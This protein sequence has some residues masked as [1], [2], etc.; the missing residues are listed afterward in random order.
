MV[1]EFLALFTDHTVRI[2]AAGATVIGFVAGSLGC[3]AYLRRQSLLGD[4]VSH[5][6]LSGITLAFIVSSVLADT[7]AKSMIVLVPGAIIA[8]SV[9]MLFAGAVVRRTKIKIDTA[10]AVTLALFFG[11]GITLMRVIQTG[12]FTDRSGLDSYIFGQAAAIT[13]ADFQA[14]VTLGAIALVLLAVFWKEFKLYTFD[15]GFA[16]S[17]GFSGRILEPLLLSTIV[18]AI[19]IGLKA[20][21]IILMIAFVIAPPSAARQWTHRLESMVLLSGGF[22]AI[23]GLLGTLASGMLGDVP[24][25][26][27]IVLF[28]TLFAVVS[29]FIA[30]KRGIVFRTIRTR[31]KRRELMAQERLQ[32]E[33]A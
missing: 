7:A 9:A 22:G 23:S 3:F 16:K 21:G 33:S 20:V 32:G 25:G 24:T 2:V 27:V 11:G 31:R 19:I 17:M 15:D 10:M 29:L 13:I 28:L 26:P 12:P 5:A 4:V 8:G 14:I 6:S 30:P 1:G 18:I